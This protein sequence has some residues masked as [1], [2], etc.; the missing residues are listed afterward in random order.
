MSFWQPCFAKVEKIK[1]SFFFHHS[2]MGTSITGSIGYNEHSNIFTDISLLR[3]SV[4]GSSDG[5][6]QP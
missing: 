4:L 6:C 3:I 1:S 2:Y 5:Q